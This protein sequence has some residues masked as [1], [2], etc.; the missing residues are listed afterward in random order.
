M[1]ADGGQVSAGVFPTG[2][3]MNRRRLA[4]YAFERGVPHGR[5]DEPTVTQDVVLSARCS[6]RAWG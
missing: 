5:G 4:E 1:A 2:V 3:G 6:P